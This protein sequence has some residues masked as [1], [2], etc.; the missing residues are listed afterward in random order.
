MRP[1]SPVGVAVLAG[2]PATGA[3]VRPVELPAGY[4]A[5]DRARTGTIAA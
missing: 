4:T 5:P 3:H 1:G 2:D